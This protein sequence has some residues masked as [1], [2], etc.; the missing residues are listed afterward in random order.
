[1]RIIKLEFEKYRNL[2][3]GSFCPAPGVNIICGSNAQ[4]KTN[5]LESIWL[6]TGGHS[7][8]GSRDAELVRVEGKGLS[9]ETASLS[10]TFFAAGREQTARLKIAAGRRSALLNGISKRSASSLVGTFCAVVFSPEHL[11]L[12]KDGPRERRLF[13][14]SAICQVRPSYAGLLSQYNRALQQRNTLLKDIAR[15]RELLDTLEIWDER[16]AGFGEAVMDERLRY[17]RT[18]RP[19]AAEIYQGISQQRE[20]LEL[21][22]SMTV[23]SGSEEKKRSML[24]VLSAR[25][26]MDLAMGATSSGPHRDDLKLTINGTDARSFGSQGQ[27]R[28][29]VLALKLAEASVLESVI[30]EPP[31]VLLDD[32]MSE[33]DVSR[34][35]YLLNQLEGRQIFITCCDPEAV[36]LLEKGKVF[37]VQEGAVREDCR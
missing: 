3:T 25:R 6:F 8:R 34:Q 18:L 24:E 15:H 26:D 10:M 19:T 7:F 31:A 14:D 28:S 29:V 13:L 16:L 9:Q 2:H 22:Y 30:G 21:S 33:L 36:R 1:M 12:V 27:Q 35:G 20:T 5:L 37:R 11:S 17:V 4:G 32:V 23:S